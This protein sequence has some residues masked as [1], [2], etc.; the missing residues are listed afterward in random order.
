MLPGFV[1][2]KF[3]HH[4]MLSPIKNDLPLGIN[5]TQQPIGNVA[6]PWQKPSPARIIATSNRDHRVA[7]LFR[8]PRPQNNVRMG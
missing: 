4:N 5:G 1:L 2:E 3:F 7:R 8:D 6:S